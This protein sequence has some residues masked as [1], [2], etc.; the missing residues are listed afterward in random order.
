[1][2]ALREPGLG[3]IVGHVSDSS[4]CIWIR[5]SDSDDEGSNLHSDRRTVGIAAVFEVAKADEKLL[6]SDDGRR[7]L[8]EKII[9]KYKPELDKQRAG[10]A[11]KLPPLYYFRLHREYDRTGTFCFGKDSCITGN[12]SA[13]LKPDTAHLA[14]M[15]TLVIDD[16]Y[17]DD[18]NVTSGRLAL[19][20]PDPEV[21]TSDLLDLG[22]PSCIAS[23]RTYKAQSAAPGPLNFVLGSCRYPGVL[24]KIKEADKIF[25]PLRCEAL[26]LN[27][28][29]AKA[30]EPEVPVTPAQFVLMAGDQVYADMM[31]RHVPLGLADTFEEFQERYH[32]AFGSRNMCKLLRQVPTYMILDDHEIED[33]WSQDRLSKAASRKVFHLAI[34]AYMSYQ[35]SHCP[36]SYQTRLY[37]NF[38]CNGYPFF[39]L[40]T[41]TQRFMDDVE[42]SLDDNHLLGRPTIGNEE[43]SQLDRLLRWLVAQQQ[44]RGD[45]PKFI[46]SSSV[47][48]PNPIDAREGRDGTDEQKVKW[49]EESDSWPAFPATRRAILGTI[50]KNG[51]Q[52]VV[53]LSGDIHCANV[54][55][56]EFCGSPAAD[57]LKAFSV[58]SSAFYWPFPFADGEPSSFVHDSKARDQRDSFQIDQQHRMDY[59]AWNFTQEDNFCRVDLDPKTQTLRVTA[60]NKKGEIV[61]KRNWIGQAT[62][63]PTISDLK[64]A[65]W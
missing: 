47:F 21:W 40:D 11:H 48:A 59:R 61:R 39:V 46:V 50:I 29:D 5:G 26:G 45:A 32:T 4:A 64:L 44:K 63:K 22:A 20:L 3:P 7:D 16:P 34:G 12:P 58:T 17:G 33:N 23:F 49:K 27:E 42:N 28:R 2:P 14:L 6:H 62:G 35:W 37:Y 54:A 1:M 18:R 31:N 43:P 9:E 24:W 55:A 36:R 8:R 13:A 25:G 51:I 60:I 65:P 10:K 56:I 57:K 53:F 19:K 52:N 38:E 30:T 15:G 41:R